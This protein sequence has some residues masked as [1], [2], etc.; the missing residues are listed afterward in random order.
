MQQLDPE[1]ADNSLMPLLDLAHPLAEPAWSGFLNRL[2]L[3]DRALFARI[4]PRFLAAFSERLWSE[5]AS[6]LLVQFLVVML[7]EERDDAVLSFAE[8]RA[9]LQA[10]DN[11]QRV[12]ALSTLR[13]RVAR[14]GWRDFGK[15][16]LEQAWPRELV[17][18]TA[19]TSRALVH[20]AKTRAT[21]SRMRRQSHPSC[22]PRP[23][24]TSLCTG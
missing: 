6:N 11:E 16:F 22:A 15:P 17:F 23:I 10:A 20:I 2:T 18:Q 21:T 7:H 8:A 24:S 4:K 13:P 9:A 14:S 12:S 3:P 19:E 5:R 1:W